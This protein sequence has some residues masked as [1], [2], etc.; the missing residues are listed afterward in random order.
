MRDQLWDP[1]CVMKWENKV[2]K[3]NVF[4]LKESPFFWDHLPPIVLVIIKHFAKWSLS[5][6]LF[7]MNLWDYTLWTLCQLPVFFI[8]FFF[9][10]HGKD[11]TQ[12]CEDYWFKC[13]IFSTT[14]VFIYF[15]SLP[16]PAVELQGRTLCLGL[17]RVGHLNGQGH[18][19][20]NNKFSFK[21]K[22][23]VL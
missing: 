2:I 20:Q 6:G 10:D 9:L 7:L 1:W 13:D 23:L 21:N 22:H 12:N 5:W 4:T 17:E 11:N 8:W 18:C 3:G 19:F 14:A 16:A 15:L